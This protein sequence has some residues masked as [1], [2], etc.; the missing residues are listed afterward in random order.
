MVGRANRPFQSAAGFAALG[1]GEGERPTRSAVLATFLA[2]LE[3]Y[4][5]GVVRFEQPVALG[6]LHVYWIGDQDSTFLRQDV[7]SFQQIKS[8]QTEIAETTWIELV[9]QGVAHTEL[10][11]GLVAMELYEASRNGKGEHIQ[12][13]III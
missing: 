5:D 8:T 4:R 10:F 7:A 13:T 1:V 6:E 11:Y 9:H 3:I 2:L 12:I